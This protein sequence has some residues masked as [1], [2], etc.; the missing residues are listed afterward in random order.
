MA[1][2]NRQMNQLID[3]MLTHELKDDYQSF[4]ATAQKMDDMMQETHGQQHQGQLKWSEKQDN[5]LRKELANGIYRQFNENFK[6]PTNDQQ[7]KN[8]TD[9]S[10]QKN[11]DGNFEKIRQANGVD[12]KGNESKDIQQ[13]KAKK[14]NQP[15]H[16]KV[17]A[18]MGKMNKIAKKMT[19]QSK[20]E[21]QQMHRMLQDMD[22]SMSQ[23]VSDESL[24][25]HI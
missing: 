10:F 22:D 11:K 12:R 4:Q 3:K 8:K 25:R 5:R 24:S 14:K 1:P 19:Q 7:I 13:N 18:P 2:A 21:V 23:N 17:V 6:E 15:A 16:K 9:R 20:Q